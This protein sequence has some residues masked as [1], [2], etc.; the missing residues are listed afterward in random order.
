M[1]SAAPRG[2][3]RVESR[4]R[5]LLKSSHRDFVSNIPKGPERP[6]ESVRLN[7]TSKRRG[8]RR[9]RVEMAENLN[10]FHRRPTRQVQRANAHPYRGNPACASWQATPLQSLSSTK[11]PDDAQTRASMDRAG[12]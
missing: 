12:L 3:K 10:K 7:S 5:R 9:G 1:R 4:C 11:Q 2:K 8:H 6:A